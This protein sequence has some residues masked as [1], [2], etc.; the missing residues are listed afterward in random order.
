[1]AAKKRKVKKKTR[2]MDSKLIAAKQPH[3]VAYAAKKSK[4][5][6]AAVRKSVKKV[7]H[8]RK[9]VMADLAAS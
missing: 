2:H 5:S 7:G 6:A 9:K 1:M 4:K 3:E 8:S